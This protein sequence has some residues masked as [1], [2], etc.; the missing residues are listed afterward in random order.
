L[1]CT[2]CSAKFLRTESAFLWGKKREH[3]NYFC[4]KKCHIEYQTG[5][6][7]PNWIKDR[8][9]IKNQHKTIRWSKE[10]EDWRNTVYNRDQWTCQMCNN[11][12]KKI[13][14]LVLN[15]HHIKCFSEYPDL[16]FDTNNGITLCEICHK[17][18]YNKEKEFEKF[19]N[20]IINRKKMNS[21]LLQLQELK[22]KSNFV[23]TETTP[24]GD[25]Y[26]VREGN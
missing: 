3:K 7:N 25:G 18:T 9:K 15:V 1:I 4:S 21:L 17:K 16:R 10:M 13:T 5:E 12:S 24:T 8:T 6:T 19:F 20:S 23:V 26:I 14:R 2:H 22:P 11:E